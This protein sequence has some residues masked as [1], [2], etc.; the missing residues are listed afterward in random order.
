MARFVLDGQFDNAV[1]GISSSKERTDFVNGGGREDVC[2]AA[3]TE[4]LEMV[5][6]PAFRELSL[7]LLAWRAIISG[8]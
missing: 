7:P 5:C 6:W 2:Q 1:T 4:W 8:G 3:T